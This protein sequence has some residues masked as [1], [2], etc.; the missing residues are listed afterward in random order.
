MTQRNN[1]FSKIALAAL[2]GAMLFPT[3]RWVGSEWLSNEYYSHGFLVLAVVAYLLWRA[4]K[5]FRADAADNRA[6]VALVVFTGAYLF[7]YFRLAYFV[8]AL[9]S[10]GI[11]GAAVW[12]LWG[13][14][15]LRRAVFPLG[16]LALAI[17]LPVVE[18]MTLPLAQWAGVASAGLVQA[19]RL[20]D[21][22]VNGAAVTLPNTTLTIGA[23]CSGINSIIALLTLT[24]LAAYLLKGPWWG[25]ALL[26]SAAIPLAM[27]GNVLRIANLIFVA[28]WWGVAAAFDFYH[29][30][31]GGIFFLLAAALLLPLSRMVQCRSLRWD[32]L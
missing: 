11:I 7:F 3:W 20:A 22:A 26:V 19:F 28:R 16:I 6:L 5:Q 12:L 27:L 9:V 8:A 1:L 23:A 31:A 14:S 4:G 32:V 10:I 30:Y 21:V 17:P 24:T 18:R 13:L 29:T 2:S 25:K 15:A